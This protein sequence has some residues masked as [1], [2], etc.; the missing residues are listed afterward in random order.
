[1]PKRAFEPAVEITRGGRVE[2]IH[3]AAVAV[4]GP[5]GDLLYGLGDPDGIIFLRSSAKPFQAAAVVASGAADRYA[6]TASELALIAG[7]HAGQDVHAAAASSILSRAGLEAGSLRC[8][9]HPP[10]DRRTAERLVKEGEPLSVLR[11]NCSGKHAGMLAAAR[12]GRH[13]VEGYLDRGHAVQRA[14]RAAI[15][16]FSGRPAEAID[17]AVDGC[18]A[19]TFG[20]SLREAARAFARLAALSSGE[21]PADPLPAGARRIVEAM[22]AHPEMVAGE[23]MLDTALMRAVPGLI[24]KVGADGVHAM[25]WLGRDGPM[26]A[27]IKVMDGDVGRGRTAVVMEVLRAT[28]VLESGQDLPQTVTGPLT[29]KS[30]SGE[31]VGEVRAIFILRGRSARPK[32]R[33]PGAR[34]NRRR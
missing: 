23:G 30:L 6:I 15:S 1:M 33:A 3:A 7:S 22:R 29:V 16:A 25:G 26:G 28:G 13:P 2:S 14:N 18:G 31:P 8:G 19:P 24:S 11:N 9:T 34:G 32:G 12:A 20:L 21:P 10:F 5:S 17:V 27:A 4:T